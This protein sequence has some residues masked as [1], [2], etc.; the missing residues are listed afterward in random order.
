ML[1]GTTCSAEETGMQAR[2]GGSPLLASLRL[3][4]SELDDAL[5]ACEKEIEAA[6]RFDEK[7]VVLDR[8]LRH[9]DGEPGA[10]NTVTDQPVQRFAKYK[11]LKEALKLY[12]ERFGEDPFTALIPRLLATAGEAEGAPGA[13]TVVLPDDD[14]AAE[15]PEEADWSPQE[16]VATAPATAPVSAA[17]PEDSGGGCKSARLTSKQVCALLANMAL[18]NTRASGDLQR[19]Y[20]S[21]AKSA[22]QKLLCLLLYFRV[23]TARSSAEFED[24]VEFSRMTTM[25]S[26]LSALI[27]TKCDASESAAVPAGDPA[28]S[29]GGASSLTSEAANEVVVSLLDDDCVDN[30]KANRLL[31]GEVCFVPDFAGALDG[32]RAALVA[33]AGPGSFGAVGDVRTPP[34]EGPLWE[35]PELLCTRAIIGSAPLADDEFFLIRGVRRIN[36][37]ATDGPLLWLVGE[38]PKDAAPLDIAA[39]D[40]SRH[41]DDQ[42]FAAKTLRRDGSKLA[43]ALG[44]LGCCSVAVS[45]PPLLGIDKHCVYAMH[46]LCSSLAASA[47]S[48]AKTVL[49]YSMGCEYVAGTEPKTELSTGQMKESNHFGALSGRMRSAGWTV[50][51]AINLIALYPFARATQT[52]KFHAFWTRRLRE[53]QGNGG[54]PTNDELGMIA[55]RQAELYPPPPTVEEIPDPTPPPA[56]PEPQTKSASPLRRPAVQPRGTAS[57]G[58]FGSSGHGYAGRKGGSGG[59]PKKTYRSRSR[60]RGRRHR[61][62][63]GESGSTGGG[64]GASRGNSGG[65]SG[66]IMSGGGGGGDFRLNKKSAYGASNSRVTGGGAVGGNSRSSVG[67]NKGRATGT[68]GVCNQRSASPGVRWMAH[69]HRQPESRSRS[70]Y[71][72]QILSKAP[73]TPSRSP[74]R[75]KYCHEILRKAP[76]TPPRDSRLRQPKAARG[77]MPLG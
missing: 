65:D 77:S 22:P 32:A 63:H 38:A 49:R 29:G 44:H 61:F 37:V 62:G 71:S 35:F 57:M 14:E 24:V 11:R 52:E 27:A 40:F 48:Q 18:L 10:D 70:R 12:E 23:A 8:W 68:S 73:V 74:S 42:R 28:T 33:L 4:G 5:A 69:N 53:K 76:M 60:S 54:R 34:E 47:D 15:E 56:S 3:R 46:V 25:G 7:F 13:A 66:R 6:T 36:R 58:A 2:S 9:F 64:Y 19:L 26:D 43:A 59:Y 39:V 51:E 45:Q 55:S 20:L 50:K 17:P 72:R 41:I 75:S 31:S 21:S 67:V 30:E 1:E 16:S